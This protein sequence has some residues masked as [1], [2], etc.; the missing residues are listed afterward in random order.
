[1]SFE[2]VSHIRSKYIAGD[3]KMAADAFAKNVATTGLAAGL[4]AA[5]GFLLKSGHVALGLGFLAA[6]IGLLLKT[7][8]NAIENEHIVDDTRKTNDM[9]S[10]LKAAH[11]WSAGTGLAAGTAAALLPCALP[12][13]IIPGVIAYRATKRATNGL[14]PQTHTNG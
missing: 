4:G 5:G 2:I 7:T 12:L 8:V 11:G 1:M 13:A 6:S 10:D 14:N 3:W 9:Y